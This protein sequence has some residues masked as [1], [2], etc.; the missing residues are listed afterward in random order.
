MDE[1]H[2]RVRAN[3]QEAIVRMRKNYSIR[4]EEGGY[5]PWDFVCTDAHILTSTDANNSTD[6]EDADSHTDFDDR[7]VSY[8][9]KNERRW[10]IPMIIRP[11]EILL[12]TPPQNLKLSGSHPGGSSGNARGLET[13]SRKHL[14]IQPVPIGGT[15]S[16]SV[17]VTAPNLRTQPS[18]S[19]G[20]MQGGRR[21]VQKSSEEGYVPRKW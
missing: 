21:S 2:N 6:T 9:I 14:G 16:Q 13:E 7:P 8:Y 3:I 11:S 1:I 17:L 10:N 18:S 12:M 4:A 5:Q 19:C 15:G 20:R